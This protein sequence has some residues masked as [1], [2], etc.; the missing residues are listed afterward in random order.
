MPFYSAPSCL[1]LEIEKKNTH[2]GKLL[3][4]KHVSLFIHS[5]RSSISSTNREQTYEQVKFRVAF[6]YRN[7]ELSMYIHTN[8][9][10]NSQEKW[11]LACGKP[12]THELQSIFRSSD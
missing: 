5:T 7:L 6:K 10:V 9:V 2:L 11:K 1:N 8:F 3:K 12:T 4:N